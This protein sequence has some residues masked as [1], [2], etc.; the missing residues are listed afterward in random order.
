MLPGIFLHF[1]RLWTLQLECTS[2]D[3]KCIHKFT[4]CPDLNSDRKTITR[5]MIKDQ[6]M[7]FPNVNSN[8][9]IVI[10][11]KF[12]RKS[13]I[14]QLIREIRWSYHM[15]NTTVRCARAPDLHVCV[16]KHSK[17]AQSVS[18]KTAEV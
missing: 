17:S 13:V 1:H 6:A 12:I 3:F 11:T 15:H 2:F 7:C 4:K 18:R 5:T 10:V 9:I 14:I 16:N 8:G